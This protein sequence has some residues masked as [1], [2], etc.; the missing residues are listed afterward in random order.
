[1]KL[2]ARAGNASSAGRTGAVSERIT[3]RFG[4]ASVGHPP[5]SEKDESEI[6][7]DRFCRRRRLCPRAADTRPLRPRWCLGRGNPGLVR[8]VEAQGLNN[9]SEVLTSALG[10]SPPVVADTDG[11]HT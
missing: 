3:G 8:L 1:M 6:E 11:I 2:I 4:V 9:L 7:G 5:R 10:R